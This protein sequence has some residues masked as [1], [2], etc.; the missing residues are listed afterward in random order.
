MFVQGWVPDST[1]LSSQPLFV[2]KFRKPRKHR[3]FLRPRLTVLD[4]PFFADACCSVRPIDLHNF[5][6]QCLQV[7]TQSVMIQLNNNVLVPSTNFSYT[8]VQYL[9][10]EL[11]SSKACCRGLG[12]QILFSQFPIAIWVGFT[13]S[14]EES[15]QWYKFNHSP[16]HMS[17]HW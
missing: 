8:S 17:P 1:S 16:G 11:R 14:L 5:E 9:L 2:Y 6:G 7:T 3:S 13:I 12:V 15:I 10:A 4:I